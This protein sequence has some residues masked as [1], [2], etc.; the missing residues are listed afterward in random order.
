MFEKTLEAQDSRTIKKAKVDF[1][2]SLNMIERDSY[3]DD[4]QE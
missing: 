1:S 4:V 3:L 2:E